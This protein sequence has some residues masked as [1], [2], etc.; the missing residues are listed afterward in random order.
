[1]EEAF[2]VDLISGVFGGIFGGVLVGTH[3]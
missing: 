3:F 2:F 1:L